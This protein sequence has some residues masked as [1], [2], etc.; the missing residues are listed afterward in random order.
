MKIMCVSGDV[1][2]HMEW[3]DRGVC[4]MRGCSCVM[5]LSVVFAQRQYSV[6]V[7]LTNKPRLQP[8]INSYFS[9]LPSN[10]Q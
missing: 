7:K 4:V 3:G 10:N 6:Y 8:S 5:A 2:V 9:A 1:M